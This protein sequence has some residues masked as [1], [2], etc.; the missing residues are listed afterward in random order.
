MLVPFG[1][2][3]CPKRLHENIFGSAAVSMLRSG[4][5]RQ[6]FSVFHII[7]GISLHMDIRYNYNMLK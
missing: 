3:L 4:T 1:V 6:F 7:F 2:S 5:L